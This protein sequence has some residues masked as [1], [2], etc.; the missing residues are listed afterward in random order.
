MHTMPHLDVPIVMAQGRLDQVAP[1]EPAQRFYDALTAP[2]KQLVWFD[3]SA[4]TPQYDQP[5]D[6]RDLLMTV[7]AR[8]LAN[9]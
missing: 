6:F 3:K 8:Y 7:R 2:G 4:H 9:T 1:A 5:A